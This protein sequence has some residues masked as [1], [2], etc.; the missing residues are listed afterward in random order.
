MFKKKKTHSPYYLEQ[1]MVTYFKA[2]LMSNIATIFF[3]KT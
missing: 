3:P 1:S 2:V